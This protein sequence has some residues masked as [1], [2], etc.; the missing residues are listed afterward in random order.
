MNRPPVGRGSGRAAVRSALIRLTWRLALPGSWSPR[1]ALGPGPLSMN[2]VRKAGVTPRTPHA[3]RLSKLVCSARRARSASSLPGLPGSCVGQLDHSSPSV[4]SVESVVQP[5]PD[6]EPR[7]PGM[8]RMM[9]G[10]NALQ[11]LARISHQKCGLLA[12]P[13]RKSGLEPG[14]VSAH[15][16]HTMGL[17]VGP[18]Q[19][20]GSHTVAWFEHWF[21][22]LACP[23]LPEFFDASAEAMPLPHS[24]SPANK[25][26][27]VRLGGRKG[28]TPVPGVEREPVRR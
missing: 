1:M 26:T 14:F 17:G 27:G 8:S 7:I 5:V 4:K 15:A 2:R 23:L 6:R 28:C 13:P 11:A 19:A 21:G 18:R 12:R 3:S 24:R 10:R 22:G 16:R 9:P 20:V 25:F